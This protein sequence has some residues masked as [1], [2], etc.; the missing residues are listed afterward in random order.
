M[1]DLLLTTCLL[2][3]IAGCYS[4]EQSAEKYYNKGMALLDKEPEKAG[5]E[6]KNA[7]QIKRDRKS[8][9]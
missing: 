9:V 3:C 5:L 2:S 7:L 1:L 4:P 6:F 8:V